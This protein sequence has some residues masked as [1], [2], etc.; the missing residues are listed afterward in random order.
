MSVAEEYLKVYKEHVKKYSD[1]ICLCWQ[2]GAFYLNDY[3]DRH[4]INS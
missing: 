1:R 4:N 2:I 3:L